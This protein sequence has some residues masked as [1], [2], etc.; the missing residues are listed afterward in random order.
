M[1]QFEALH[2][3]GLQHGGVGARNITLGADGYA[4]LID[5][6]KCK[7]HDC[8]GRGQCSELTGLRSLLGL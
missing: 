2:A 1:A 5:F 8:L 4:R 3:A 7:P 6:G